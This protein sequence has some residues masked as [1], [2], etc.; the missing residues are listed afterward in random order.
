MTEI[1]FSRVWAMPN[2]C[3]FDVPPIGRF[4]RKYL[5]ESHLSIDP[6]AR[7]NQWATITNDLNPETHADYH[8]DAVAFLEYLHKEE[9]KSDLLIFDPPYTVRQVMEC[10]KSVGRTVTMQDTQS[11]FWSKIRS[12][13]MSVLSKDSTVLSFGYST[14]GMGKKRG[15]EIIEIMLVCGGGAHND[16]ICMAERRIQ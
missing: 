8:L 10:Y 15:F 3:T 12:A 14:V 4:V 13:A 9:I 5:A 11:G 7:D 1:L 2:R 6:F 16:T